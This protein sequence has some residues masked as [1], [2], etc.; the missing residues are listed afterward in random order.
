MFKILL[1]LH[2]LFAVFAVGPLVHAAT[3]A[4]RGVRTGNGIATAYS[5]RMLKIYSYASVLVILVGGGLMSSKR[6]GKTVAEFSDVWIWLSVL[7]WL[8]AVALVLALIVP[9]LER[10]TKLI[11]EQQSVV[12][13]TGRVA[14]AGGIVGLIFA[15]IVFLMVY[16]PGS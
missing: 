4:A 10:A 13:L 3:T 12:S 1:A 9:A 5:A 16:Q 8:V 2:L 14:A 6:H 7:L 15:A 11:A